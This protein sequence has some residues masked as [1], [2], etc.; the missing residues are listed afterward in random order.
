MSARVHRDELGQIL[1]NSLPDVHAHGA[2][3]ADVGGFSAEAAN[4]LSKVRRGVGGIVEHGVDQL[5][6]TV[7]RVASAL[8]AK[9][10]RADI[11]MLSQSAKTAQEAAEA[12]GCAL[13]QIVKSLVLVAG[14]QPF[15][16]LVSG[17]NRVDME[18]LSR[19]FHAPVRRAAPDE[20]KAATGFAIGGVPPLGHASPLQV[21]VDETLLTYETVWAAAGH[22]HSVFAIA[23]S[24]LVRACGGRVVDLKEE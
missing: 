20:V 19:L 12:V 14:D 17:E 21:V 11:R 16:A 13:G 9:G 7:R 1:Q 5:P 6:E 24:E 10:V 2:D 18:K 22:P 4:M 15:I 8:E 23:P 3:C